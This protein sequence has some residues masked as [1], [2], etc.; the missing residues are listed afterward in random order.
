MI[1]SILFLSYSIALS[2]LFFVNCR[3][4]CTCACMDYYSVSQSAAGHP[5]HLPDHTVEGERSPPC[6]N[7]RCF[8]STT[9]LRRKQFGVSLPKKHEFSLEFFQGVCTYE[10]GVEKG[11]WGFAFGGWGF[12]VFGVSPGWFLLGVSSSLLPPPPRFS[13]PPSSRLLPGAPFRHR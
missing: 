8:L 10:V 11:V 2:I 1:V 5:C 3:S 7:L 12:E 9:F 6:P 4:A 13:P